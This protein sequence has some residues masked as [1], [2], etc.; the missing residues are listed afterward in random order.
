MA[1][2]PEIGS[3]AGREMAHDRI[4]SAV[5]LRACERF[6]EFDDVHVGASQYLH[7]GVFGIGLRGTSE[8]ASAQS[9]AAFQQQVGAL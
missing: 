1:H 2:A 5:V 9:P 7:Q 6:L 8:E 3:T 4:E